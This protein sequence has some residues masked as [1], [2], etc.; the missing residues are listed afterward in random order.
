MYFDELG[1]DFEKFIN[2]YDTEQRI[3]LIFR[4]LQLDSMQGLDVLEVGCGTGRISRQIV[5]RNAKLTVL[6]IGQSLVKK[7]ARQ[8]NCR[9]V[10][11]DACDLPFDCDSFDL[12]ISSEC[13]EHTLDPAKAIREMVRVCKRHGQICI[14]SPN[15]LWYPL[16]WLSVRLGVRHFRGMEHWLWPTQAAKIMRQTGM[17]QV[18]IEGCHLW[19]FQLTFTRPILKIIDHAGCILWPAMINYAVTASG[20]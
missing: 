18:K 11:A 20:K 16:L 2:D 7:V 14:T 4:M 8:L 1:E 6:D 12:V 17:K 9:G 15:K 19:P 10:T 5:E 13:I 3:R